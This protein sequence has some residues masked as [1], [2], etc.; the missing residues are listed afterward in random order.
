MLEIMLQLELIRERL[1]NKILPI[2]GS[3]DYHMVSGVLAV[4]FA[5]G[6]TAAG[7][8]P[9][10]VTLP[11]GGFVIVITLIMGVLAMLTII[12]LPIGLILL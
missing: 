8:L 5:G 3:N 2:V 12:L 9:L 10:P 4:I 6:T 1:R 11:V 7:L